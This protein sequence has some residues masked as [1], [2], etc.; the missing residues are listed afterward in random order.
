MNPAPLS[1]SIRSPRQQCLICH[2]LQVASQQ[3]P[4]THPPPDCFTLQ[5]CRIPTG[6]SR[7]PVAVAISATEIL[8][9][10]KNQK[11]SYFPVS[12]NRVNPVPVGGKPANGRKL[13]QARQTLI[14]F[15]R[16]LSPSFL[17]HQPLACQDLASLF[18]TN[19]GLTE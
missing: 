7:C 9:S 5:P 6:Q 4:E 8:K 17:F 2:Q 18:A 1:T 19:A 15:A 16:I 13:A 12:F 10:R 14:C 11:V 3:S